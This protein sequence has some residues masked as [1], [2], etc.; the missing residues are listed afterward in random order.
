MP[1]ED[2]AP[3]L[4]PLLGTPELVDGWITSQAVALKDGSIRYTNYLNTGRG[5]LILRDALD[6]SHPESP[7]GL[8]RRFLAGE[9]YDVS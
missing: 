2:V 5:G 4:K 1:R 8:E 9:R 7:Q 3:G 6:P